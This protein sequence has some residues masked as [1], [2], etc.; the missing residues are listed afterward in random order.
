MSVKLP[1]EKGIQISNPTQIALGPDSILYAANNTGE[2]YS[3]QDTDGD[4]LEDMARLYCNIKDYGLRSPS[5]FSFRGDTI[6]IGTAEGI[7]AFLDLDRDGKADTSWLFFNDI[8][9][10]AHPYKWT[11]GMGLG[12]DGWLYFA[13]TTDSWNA[14]ASPDPQGYR[15]GYPPGITGW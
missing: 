8:P 12:P 7:S 11:S 4:G 10:S 1:I 13:L 3:L 2:I 14:G 15:G 5:G 9:T 6:Y